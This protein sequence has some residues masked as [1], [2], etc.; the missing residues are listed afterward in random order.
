MPP[1]RPSRRRP[2]VSEPKT[3]RARSK[4]ADASA[5]NPNWRLLSQAPSELARALE[6]PGL[7]SSSALPPAQWSAPS[8][9]SPKHGG[10][11]PKMRGQN[12]TVFG[13]S[14]L[15]DQRSFRRDAAGPPPLVASCLGGFKVPAKP[16]R[17]DIRSRGSPRSPGELLT[18]YLC[19]QK[20]TSSVPRRGTDRGLRKRCPLWAG[21]VFAVFAYTK[22]WA[23]Q[24][25]GPA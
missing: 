13:R 14:L 10:G 11:F 17:E 22:S 7:H 24:D 2:R 5:D 19:A 15:R 21:E 12:L 9:R 18:F 20:C 23:V 16:G 3:C 8:S 1:T 25:A 6:E 4:G